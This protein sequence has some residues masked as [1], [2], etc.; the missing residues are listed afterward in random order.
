[1]S[2][3]IKRLNESTRPILALHFL[4]LSPADRYLRFAAAVT[5]QS[6]ARYVEGIDFN[7]DAVF[8]VHPAAIGEE[9]REALAGVVHA[10]FPDDVAEL[11]ISVLPAYRGQGL[12][13]TLAEWAIA[14]ARSRG[15]RWLSMQLLRENAPMLRIARKL[16]MTVVD[17]GTDLFARLE[18]I[19]RNRRRGSRSGTLRSIEK[20]R[21]AT[22]ASSSEIMSAW[23]ERCAALNDVAPRQV[24]VGSTPSAFLRRALNV[25]VNEPFMPGTHVVTDRALY[26][27]HGIYVGDGRVVHYAGLCSGWQGGPV[28]EVS[29]REFADGERVFSIAHSSRPFSNAEIVARARSRL[30]ENMYHILRN[31]CEH[32]CEWCVTGR[33]RSRQ[34]RKWMSLPSRLLRTVCRWG[35]DALEVVA[36]AA[37]LCL[38]Q[39]TLWDFARSTRAT[40]VGPRWRAN[41]VEAKDVPPLYRATAREGFPGKVLGRVRPYPERARSTASPARSG[42]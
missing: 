16:G 1:M 20:A 33:K 12:A 10:A 4:A 36:L 32:F 28:E 40:P 21:H 18:L 35:V 22:G 3:A 37:R 29:I 14:Y 17:R 19:C 5:P 11:G 38:Y 26:A 15:M 41:D 34:V 9:C 25:Q 2:I 7:R 24:Q 13:S 8:A 27:H 39:S 6:I 42:S 30:G 31:N 23:L